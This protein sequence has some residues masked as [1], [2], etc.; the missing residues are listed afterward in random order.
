MSLRSK[1]QKKVIGSI[2]IL[3]MLFLV[4]CGSSSSESNDSDSTETKK[5]QLRIGC[6]QTPEGFVWVKAMTEV[7]MPEVNRILA[8]TGDYEV[9][10]VEA[11]GGTVAKTDECLEAVE[12][13]LL[14][15]TWVGYV[16]EPSKLLLGNI[17]YHAP[18]AAVDVN[19][20]TEAMLKM[21]DKYPE[22]S[23]EWEQYNQILLG[24]SIMESYN[25]MSK[26]EYKGLADLAG[27][28][29]GAAGANLSWLSGSGLTPVQSN[30]TE[31]YN[32][33]QTGVYQMGMQSTSMLKNL[34]LY[35]VAPNAIIGNFGTVWVG[36]VS[37]NKGVLEGLPEE[38]QKAIMEAGKAYT[39]ELADM[40]AQ[41][42]TDS[43]KYLEQN[44]DSC[45]F[46]TNEE[47]VE[48][49]SKL[50]NVP[51]L[52]IEQLK[53]EGYDKGEELFASYFQLLKEAGEVPIRDWLSE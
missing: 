9:D 10:W 35:E 6:G 14:D 15:I 42:Y 3:L 24:P 40:T 52:Y 49:A 46:F 7:F 22:L 19:A 13:G 20:S 36:G 1:R 27:K 31:A 34:F 5:I 17:T 18:L 29:A 23:E 50:E 38:V 51:K 25:I 16:F 45:Y 48:W 41:A 2:L 32:A 33:L 12:S 21:F 4:G 28:K 47:R 39:L 53:N 37:I 11:W 30:G 8:E 26:F 44:C 43:L